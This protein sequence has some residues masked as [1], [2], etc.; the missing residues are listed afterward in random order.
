MLK[1][2]RIF[3]LSITQ[4]FDMIKAHKTDIVVTKIIYDWE[5]KTRSRIWSILHLEVQNQIQIHPGYVLRGFKKPIPTTNGTLVYKIIL[6]KK[7]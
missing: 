4:K 2:I 3:L 6:K 1:K 5:N 7:S